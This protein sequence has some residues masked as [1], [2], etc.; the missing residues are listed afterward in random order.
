MTQLLKSVQVT[1]IKDSG[2][3]LAKL[4]I[5]QDQTILGNGSGGSNQV[6][7]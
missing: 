3:T 5:L 4:L 7:K 1:R 6:L 2:V